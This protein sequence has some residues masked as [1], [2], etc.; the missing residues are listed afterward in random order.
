[1]TFCFGFEIAELKKQK[2][3]EVQKQIED[4][5]II[6]SQIIYSLIKDIYNSN[7]T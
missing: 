4:S 3:R 6:V 2:I 5:K 1:M 7:L